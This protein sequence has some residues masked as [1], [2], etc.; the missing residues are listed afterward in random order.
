MTKLNRSAHALS[1]AA[2]TCVDVILAIVAS[3]DKNSKYGHSNNNCEEM[4]MCDWDRGVCHLNGNTFLAISVEQLES[5]GAYA[6]RLLAHHCRLGPVCCA[7]RV[8]GTL[9]A[10]EDILHAQLTLG[11]VIVVFIALAFSF[12]TLRADAQAF[13]A[14]NVLLAGFVIVG[15]RQAFLKRN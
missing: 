3:E 2:V 10:M 6:L 12:N 11:L 1:Y 9:V 15:F 7:M 4:I 13:A 8:F 5:V 14:L